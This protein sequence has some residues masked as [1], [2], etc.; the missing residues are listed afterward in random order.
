[1]SNEN[2]V[3]ERKGDRNRFWV[4]VILSA[5]LGTYLVFDFEKLGTIIGIDWNVSFSIEDLVDLR[6]LLIIIGVIFI[7]WAFCIRREDGKWKMPVIND[8]WRGSWAASR[9]N[10]LVGRACNQ[11]AC[12][13]RK[14][15]G[16][17]G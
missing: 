17:H 15:W 3:M 10:S 14:W 8:V 13:R 9:R 5:I 16:G 4:L 11:L 12:G 7:L 2:D 6:V 1:M